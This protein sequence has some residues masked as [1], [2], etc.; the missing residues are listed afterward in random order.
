M[1]CKPEPAEVGP[2]LVGSEAETNHGP[3]ARPR[4]R[5]GLALH[6]HQCRYIISRFHTV[7]DLVSV[8]GA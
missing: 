3:T 5:L 1:E 8:I 7:E 4:S 6:P 2:W